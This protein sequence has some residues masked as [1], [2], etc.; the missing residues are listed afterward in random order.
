[1]LE[2]LFSPQAVAILGA[3][4]NPGKVGHAFVANLLASGYQGK[5][6][7]VNPEAKDVLGVPCFRDLRE[8]GGKI[9]L[10]VIVVPPRF[11]KQAIQDC[12]DAGAK[13]VTVITAGFAFPAP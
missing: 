13:V 6:V 12:I 5:I 1:M 7:P 4:R 8:Y 9:D 3:S 10:G 2:Q 11:V